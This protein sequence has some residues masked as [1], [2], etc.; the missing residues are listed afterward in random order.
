MRLFNALCIAVL[1]AGITSAGFSEEMKRTATIAETSGEVMIKNAGPG[2]WASAK[3]GDVL[4][5][6]S[7]LKTGSR[8]KAVINIDGDSKTAVVDVSERS[9]VSFETLV[10]D[11]MTGVK[12]TLLDLSIG[13]V[14]IKAE[15][16]D[17]PDSKFE[18][19]TP[20]SVV[21]VRG[22]KFSVKVDALK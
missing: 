1:I 19:K 8:A 7:F 12:K 11:S 9:L 20:T 17:T 5:E 6:G 3:V 15:K 2:S 16:L 14:L 4:N 13:Q 18:V 21:G 22:T 10:K